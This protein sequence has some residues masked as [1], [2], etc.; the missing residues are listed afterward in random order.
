MFD[1]GFWEM[2]FI[3]IIALVVIGPEKL[4]AAAKTAGMWVGKA[5]RMVA[6]VKADIKREMEENDTLSGVN[7]LKNEISNVSKNVKKDIDDNLKDAGLKNGSGGENDPLGIKSAGEAIKSTVDDVS[8]TFKE[9]QTPPD[10]EAQ[11]GHDNSAEQKQS[12]TTQVDGEATTN[13]QSTSQSVTSKKK[14]A[15]KKVTKKKVTKKKVAKKAATKK[16]TS[17]K[18]SS[19]KASN[20][21]KLTKKAPA[22]IAQ[23]ASSSPDKTVETDNS[24][25]HNES[26]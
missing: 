3:S 22:P 10:D 2:A 23:D 8:S 7:D 21:K 9:A 11:E 5:R 16:K 4:P 24:A 13:T 12:S 1:I 18:T 6:D 14:T 26:P 20:K 15:K 19:K 17:K 25:Q